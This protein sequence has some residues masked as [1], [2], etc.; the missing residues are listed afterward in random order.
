MKKNSIK[1]YDKYSVLRIET[2]INDPHEF[3]IYRKV[4]HKNEPV[5][6]WVPMGKSVANIYRYAQVSKASNVRYLDA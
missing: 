5:M 2:T 3:K 6:A 1:M 4:N